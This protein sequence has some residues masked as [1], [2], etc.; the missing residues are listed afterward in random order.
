MILHTR[1]THPHSWYATPD[2]AWYVRDTPRCVIQADTCMIQLSWYTRYS[3]IRKCDTK[4][5]IQYDVTWYRRDTTV[6][7]LPSPPVHETHKLSKCSPI[8]SWYAWYL[9]DTSMIRS[10]CYIRRRRRCPGWSGEMYRAYIWSIMMYHTC[11]TETSRDVVSRDII[12]YHR[13][14]SGMHVSWVS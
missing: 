14:V 2:T 8:R 1:I 10:H 13:S 3:L 5:A 6:L 11:I 4:R 9:C 12:M 7:H